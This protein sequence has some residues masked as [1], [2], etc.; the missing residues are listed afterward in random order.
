M[1]AFTLNTTNDAENTISSLDLSA[2]PHTLTYNQGYILYLQNGEGADITVNLLGD[3]VT[4]GECP[5]YG[6]ID[7]SAG[8]DIVVPAGDTVA[9]R[10][11]SY[12]KFRGGAGNTSNV[13]ITGATSLSTGWVVA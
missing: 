12:S 11:Q 3:G 9:V 1:A 4:T 10:L 13:T 7:L 6:S 2:G 5:G 8:K